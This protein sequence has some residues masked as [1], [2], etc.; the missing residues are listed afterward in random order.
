MKIIRNKI[1]EYIVDY[2]KG[3][4]MM[5]IVSVVYKGS[6]QSVFLLRFNLVKFRKYVESGSTLS[7]HKLITRLKS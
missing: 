6:I 4:A 7:V 5:S 1:A 2:F 3:L